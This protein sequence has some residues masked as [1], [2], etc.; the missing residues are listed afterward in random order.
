MPRSQKSGRAAGT[1]RVADHAESGFASLSASG[2]A[3]ATAGLPSLLDTLASSLTGASA[4]CSGGASS[5]LSLSGCTAVASTSESSGGVATIDLTA[6][7]L[8]ITLSLSVWFPSDLSLQL[9]D[10]T[11][12]QIDG[13]AADANPAFQSSR[14]RVLAGGHDVTPLL[15]TASQALS[16]VSVPAAVTLEAFASPGGRVASLVVRGA[17]VGSGTISLQHSL[18]VTREVVVPPASPP[19]KV[20]DRGPV[21]SIDSRALAT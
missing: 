18:G 17:A 3:E 11:L 5:M 19:M 1:K 4:S 7:D 14:L 13:C 20:A 10:A 2:F 6:G 9:D 8:L 15:G 21:A 12:N 16:L